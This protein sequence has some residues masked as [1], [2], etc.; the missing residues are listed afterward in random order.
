[1]PC[2]LDC[3]GNLP[4]E[5]E[6]STGD[7]ARQNLALLVEEPLEELSILVVNIL[8]TCLLETAVFLLANLYCRRVQ[9]TDF[10]VLCHSLVLLDYSAFL[11]ALLFSA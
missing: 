8:D 6:G 9:I 1:M 4:L 11:F 5:L 7:A 3:L 2:P 10:I